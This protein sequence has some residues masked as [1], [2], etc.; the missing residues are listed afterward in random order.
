MILNG[1]TFDQGAEFVAWT[2]I[3]KSLNTNV[4]FTY[5]R[6]PWQKGSNENTNGL[7]RE[8]LLKKCDFDKVSEHELM[9]IVYNLNNR[10]RKCLGFRTP[11]EVFFEELRRLQL[12]C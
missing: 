4:Y 12:R 3:E 5:P 6:S 8:Y 7:L 2:L 9:K 11:Q 1:F 10:P